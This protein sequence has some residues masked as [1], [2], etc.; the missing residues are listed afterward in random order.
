MATK[1]TKTKKKAKAKKKATKKR[2]QK[3]DPSPAVKMA[4]ADLKPRFC[5]IHGRKLRRD[6]TCPLGHCPFHETPVPHPGM[7]RGRSG[8]IA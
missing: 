7:T 5:P 6:G 3:A 4:A 1:K 8:C 2:I